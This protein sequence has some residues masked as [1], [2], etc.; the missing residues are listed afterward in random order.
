MVVYASKYKN[1][2]IDIKLIANKLSVS[3][4]FIVL[5]LKILNDIKMIDIKQYNKDC[6]KYEFLASKE[7]NAITN[8]NKFSNLSNEYKKINNRKEYEL[9]M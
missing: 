6:I 5:F 1:G 9:S 8:H 3:L 2:E 7:M 4:K